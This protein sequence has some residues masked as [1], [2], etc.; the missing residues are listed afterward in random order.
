MGKKILILDDPQRDLIH[1]KTAFEALAGE[2]SHIQIVRSRDELFEEMK[3]KDWE[4]LVID[5]VLE[6][7]R[8]GGL[9]V[10][11][12][13][14]RANKQVPIA[15]VVS[16]EDADSGS[17]LISAGATD[18][19]I[20]SHR[21]PLQSQLPKLKRLL[22]LI[23]ANRK[24]NLQCEKRENAE[25]AK[26][27]MVGGSPQIQEVISKIEKVAA[28]PR[29]ILIT[30]PRGT[31]K[32]LVARAIHKA[33]AKPGAPIL[34]VNCAAFSDEL[35]DSTLFGHERGSFT[36]AESRRVGKFEQADGGTLF[37]DEI[38]NM[39]T[40]FQQKIMRVVEYGTFRRVG[41][42]E[43]IKVNTRVIA[44][45]NADMQEKMDKGEFMRDLY[46]RLAFEVIRLPPL[47]E[48][49][50]DIPLL[51]NFFMDR[52][53][54]EIPA[55]RG[56]KLSKK[57]LSILEQYPFPGNIR[58]LKNIIERAVY[59]DTTNEISPEDLD[60]GPVGDPV[61]M[62]EGDTFDEKVKSFELHLLKNALNRAEG[63]QAEAARILGL[64]YHQFRY[65]LKKY[66]DELDL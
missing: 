2:K 16:A 15:M 45:T 26:F 28:I 40:S 1:V 36:G 12:Q 56:K 24:L 10:L 54:E 31:G 57:A 27:K 34:V 58:E 53:M 66:K 50:G 13:I 6:G 23:E 20:D 59:R 14:R 11:S 62:I 3:R 17:T 33:G 44:A 39:S 9:K 42:Q 60:L 19:L 7:N 43:E 65:H 49:K 35:L 25:R 55:F 5:H 37:L 21:V 52:F 4:L 48:R 63:N 8:Q 29:P 22:D 64:S 38:G 30:G 51:A 32:E 41:G 61:D 18:Y 46:D 47:R